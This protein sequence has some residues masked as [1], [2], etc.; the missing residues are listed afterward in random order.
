MT[1][2]CKAL[3]LFL[4]LFASVCVAVA[5]PEDGDEIWTGVLLATNEASPRPMPRWLAPYSDK[6]QKML[7]YNQ[8]KVIGRNVER[9][10]DSDGQWLIPTKQFYLEVKTES[11]RGGVYLLHFTLWHEKKMLLETKAKV[12]PGSPLFVRGPQYGRGQVVFV[13]E[14]R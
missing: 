11:G 3:G 6:L 5:A 1:R 4:L 7:G 12:M 10:R 2:S 14:V 8:F 9:M 13:V